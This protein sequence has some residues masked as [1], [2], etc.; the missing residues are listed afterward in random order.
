MQVKQNRESKQMIA[1]SESM[2]Q[3]GY[4]KQMWLWL[5]EE[6]CTSQY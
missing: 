6:G 2:F 4:S 5:Y 1:H 3:H